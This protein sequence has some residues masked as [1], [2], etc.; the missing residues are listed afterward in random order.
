[1]PPWSTGFRIASKRPKRQLL[2]WFQTTRLGQGKA[3]VWGTLG[4]MHPLEGSEAT[5]RCHAEII[6]AP[7]RN[8]G[9]SLSRGNSRLKTERALAAPTYDALRSN[10][11]RPIVVLESNIEA[12]KWSPRVKGESISGQTA[13]GQVRTAE[14]GRRFRIESIPQNCVR[15]HHQGCW[16]GDYPQ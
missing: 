10:E 15:Q 13:G 12:S 8:R 4:E 3:M 11:C 9:L 14:T 5:S 16:C 6:S 2:P 7:A 1:M